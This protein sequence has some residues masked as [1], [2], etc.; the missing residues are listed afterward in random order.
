MT[1]K[2]IIPSGKFHC[3]VDDID[4]LDFSKDLRSYI[5]F[6][7]VRFSILIRSYMTVNSTLFDSIKIPKTEIQCRLMQYTV[8]IWPN[9]NQEL[10]FTP[11]NPES[12]H[13]IAWIMYIALSKE[14]E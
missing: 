4:F 2:L 8:P 10:F 7:S 1:S 11:R 6:A 12:Y 9:K 14:G 5:Y 13:Y 3:S